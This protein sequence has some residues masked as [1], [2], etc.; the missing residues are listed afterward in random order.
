MKTFYMEEGTMTRE[1]KRQIEREVALDKKER[2]AKMMKQ[3]EANAKKQENY[4]QQDG[5]K[6]HLSSAKRN[7]ELAEICKYAL[8]GINSII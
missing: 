5:V 4:Y 3:F 2:I 1:E 6:S 7:A 8:L